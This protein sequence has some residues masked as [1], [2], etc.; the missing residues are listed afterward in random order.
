M[1]R[2]LVAEPI[3]ITAVRAFPGYSVAGHAP[4]VLVHACLTNTETATAMPA[5]KE[6]SAAA[7]TLQKG[8]GA[9]SFSARRAG[10]RTIH[11]TGTFLHNL[12]V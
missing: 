11:S 3:V 1:S 6:L 9:P 8:F 4:K 12:V 2:L 10:G 7:H 5:E